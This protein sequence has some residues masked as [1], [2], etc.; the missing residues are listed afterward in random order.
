M[1]EQNLYP[2]FYVGMVHVG[3]DQATALPCVVVV[4]KDF[5]DE[6]A[7]AAISIFDSYKCRFLKRLFCFDGVTATHGN[8]VVQGVPKRYQPEPELGIDWYRRRQI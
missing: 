4:A 1:L 2:S 7:L 8:R 6:H 3:F 5:M